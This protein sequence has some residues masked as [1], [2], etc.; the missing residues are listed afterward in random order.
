MRPSV[1][2]LRQSHS[3]AS[4]TCSICSQ[5]IVTP[6]VSRSLQRRSP[7][8]SNMWIAAGSVPGDPHSCSSVRLRRLRSTAPKIASAMARGRRHLPLEQQDSDVADQQR[9]HVLVPRPRPDAVAL[10]QGR[11]GR[12]ERARRERRAR[13]GQPAQRVDDAGRAEIEHAVRI[14]VPGLVHRMRRPECI[15]VEAGQP[16]L[17]QSERCRRRRRRRTTGSRSAVRG[18]RDRRVR[19]QGFLETRR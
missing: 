6:R 14:G 16:R 18:G 1:E 13:G 17:R 5:R 10:Q 19:R 2:V 11:N 12:L 15:R 3:P 7:V 8:H 4:G 9:R